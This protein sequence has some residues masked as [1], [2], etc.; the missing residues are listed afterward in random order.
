MRRRQF[1]RGM[2]GRLGLMAAAVIVLATATQPAE[3]LSVA[4]PLTVPATK[5]A[6]DGH[7]TEVRFGG[8]GGGGF[9]GGG[10][11]GGGFRGGGAAFHRGGGF[12][13]GGFGFHRGYRYGGF[14]RYYGFHRRHFHRGFY[15]GSSYYHPRR[16]RVVWTHY[17]PRR[18]CRPWW[19]RRAYW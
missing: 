1:A 13:G 3:A 11:R 7:A 4:S 17:G 12:R 14:H 8:H 5:A 10:F 15:Y 19:H 6:T 16:C 9:R 2:I 18:I